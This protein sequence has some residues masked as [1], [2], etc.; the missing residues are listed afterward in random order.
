M[1]TFLWFLGKGPVWQS[2]LPD[3]LLFRSTPTWRSRVDRK[4]GR[5]Q[6]GAN[7]NQRPGAQRPHEHKDAVQATSVP[8][9]PPDWTEEPE[10]QDNAV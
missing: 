7:V 6:P 4:V 5:H 10:V 3:Y 9:P 8:E 1:S 2:G